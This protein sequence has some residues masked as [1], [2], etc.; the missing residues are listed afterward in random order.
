MAM[1]EKTSQVLG[2]PPA[3]PIYVATKDKH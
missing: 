3:P 2:K 1:V